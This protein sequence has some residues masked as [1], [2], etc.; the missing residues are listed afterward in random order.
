MIKLEAV[1][2]THDVRAA[3]VLRAYR[4]RRAANE[5]LMDRYSSYSLINEDNS[6]YEQGLR[7]DNGI[8]PDLT[9][10]SKHINDL[11]EEYNRLTGANTEHHRRR[12]VYRGE[13][14]RSGQSYTPVEV[15]TAD[16]GCWRPYTGQNAPLEIV[17]VIGAVE[18]T[19]LD[20]VTAEAAGVTYFPGSAAALFAAAWAVAESGYY[21]AE[22]GNFFINSPR[23]HVATVHHQITSV[24]HIKEPLRALNQ[25][26]HISQVVN[27]SVIRSLRQLQSRMSEARTEYVQGHLHLCSYKLFGALLAELVTLSRADSFR[28]L[29]SMSKFDHASMVNTTAGLQYLVDGRIIDVVQHDM[30]EALAGSTTDTMSDSIRLY[31]EWAVLLAPVPDPDAILHIGAV[32]AGRAERL[33]SRVAADAHRSG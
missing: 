13:Q 2:H 3:N 6:S 17:S 33:F 5:R 21:V 29:P 30:M 18:R 27:I 1:H 23:A 19:D 11:G 32:S 25:P 8:H 12:L 9:I 7:L 4:T 20:Y 31:A 26:S 15:P 10:T 14:L 16:D 24:A 28:H 22:D